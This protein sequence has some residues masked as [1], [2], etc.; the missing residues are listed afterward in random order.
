MP[1]LGPMALQYTPT[2]VKFI[3]ALS[4]ERWKAVCVP[5]VA[6][7]VYNMVLKKQKTL[8]NRPKLNL[9]NGDLCRLFVTVHIKPGAQ[10]REGVGKTCFMD[11]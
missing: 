2:A 3:P 10:K 9:C 1:K 11:L 8:A 4:E 5:T 6:H 7:T